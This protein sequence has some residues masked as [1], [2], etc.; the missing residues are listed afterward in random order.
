MIMTCKDVFIPF[1]ESDQLCKIIPCIF[2][3]KP[4]LHSSRM[5]RHFYQNCK[6]FNLYKSKMMLTNAL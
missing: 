6:A 3:E 5:T 2:S 1:G 4:R